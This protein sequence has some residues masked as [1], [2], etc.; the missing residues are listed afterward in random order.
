MLYKDIICKLQESMSRVIYYQGKGIVELKIQLPDGQVKQLPLKVYI[1]NAALHNVYWDNN[2][3]GMEK[4]YAVGGWM[5]D[6]DLEFDVDD[7]EI[8]DDEYE[9]YQ[10]PDDVKV[11]EIVDIKELDVE[12][13]DGDYED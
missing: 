4:P 11:L 12:P 7:I 3:Y 9:K 10:L 1:S 2:I 6:S 13:Y 8:D 5:S